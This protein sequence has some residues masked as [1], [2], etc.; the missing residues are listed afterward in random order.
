MVL[1]YDI[2][3]THDRYHDNPFPGPQYLSI[4]VMVEKFVPALRLMFKLHEI[5]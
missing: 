2:S 3:F 4:C 1:F 5:Q